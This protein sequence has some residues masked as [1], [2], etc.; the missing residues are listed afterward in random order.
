LSDFHHDARAAT[1]VFN[2]LGELWEDSLV[3]FVEFLGSWSVKV[4]HLHC[5]DLKAFR[6]D[7]IY[8]L[9]SLSRFDNVRLDN[10]ASTIIE[11]SSGS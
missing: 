4:E 6:K 8:N 1:Q 2:H 9:S 7:N 3:Y 10:G 11:L 5:R